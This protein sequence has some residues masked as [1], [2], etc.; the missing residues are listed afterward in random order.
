MMNG[1]YGNQ[2]MHPLLLQKLLGNQNGHPME[3]TN[4]NI[5]RMMCLMFLEEFLGNENDD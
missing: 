2:L 4:G 5:N 1:N 3:M